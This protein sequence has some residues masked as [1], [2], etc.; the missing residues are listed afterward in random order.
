MAMIER[1]H[2]LHKPWTFLFAA[3]LVSL[4]LAAC[5]APKRS[6]DPRVNYPLTVSKETVV[7]TVTA[8]AGGASLAGEEVRNFKDFVRAYLQRGLGRLNVKSGGAGK[9]GRPGAERVR[10]LLMKEG[11]RSG[12]I[13][14]TEAGGGGG[15][16]V[17][18]SFTAHAVKVPEC[19]DFS[20]SATFNWSNRTDSNFGCSYRRNL[21][22]MVRDPGDLVKS[23]PMS[24]ADA[25]RAIGVITGYRSGGAGE[26]EAA[27]E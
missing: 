2:L 1:A 6:N 9:E 10:S 11:V 19:G 27:A 15:R 20:S 18:L 3:V 26:A 25:N 16:A 21:G 7:L 13:S 14:I 4:A 17:T 22:L 5:E 8:P 23:K 12:E 24:G